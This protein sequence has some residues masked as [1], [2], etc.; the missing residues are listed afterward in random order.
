[1]PRQYSKI[2]RI[3][4]GKRVNNVYTKTYAAPPVNEREILRYIGVKDRQAAGELSVMIRECVA[5]AEK[6]LTYKVSYGE[7][8]LA[9]ADSIR[10]ADMNIN[11]KD[12]K[13]NLSGC[14]S[15]F[16]F[17]ATVG[18]EIDRL[19]ARYSAT[20]P[21][22]ALIFDGIG[23]E[24]IESLCDAFCRDMAQNKAR[25]G[26]SLRPRFGAG[27]GD[28]SIEAQRDIFR[29]L[30]CPRTLGL[31]LLDSMLMSPTKSVTAIVGVAEKQE[32][33]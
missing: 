30:D 13:K 8:D 12:L 27:Y 7:F 19:I 28:F 18:I 29:L 31:T 9:V 24:R 33:K 22:K 11:S 15:A 5:I 3:Y 23:A 6:K 1:M 16:V 10:L 26:Y 32:E 20:S 2:F 4:W 25:E 21:A 17:A 14:K